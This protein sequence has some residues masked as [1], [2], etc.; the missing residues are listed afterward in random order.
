MG[1]EAIRQIDVRKIAQ[2]LRLAGVQ[3]REAVYR[4]WQGPFSSFSRCDPDRRCAWSDMVDMVFEL[5][6]EIRF[7]VNDRK[8]MRTV[9]PCGAGPST[10][11]GMCGR[12]KPRTKLDTPG[13]VAVDS[14]RSTPKPTQSGN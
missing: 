4:G 13:A 12:P 11:Y 9:Q 10:S 3:W 7:P 1:L 8:T 2:E 14:A 6:M 5:N